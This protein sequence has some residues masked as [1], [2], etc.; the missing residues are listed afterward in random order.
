[1]SGDV[2]TSATNSSTIAAG[3]DATGLFFP[4]E[5]AFQ[6]TDLADDLPAGSVLHIGN[7]T[8]QGYDTYNK[9]GRGGWN[10]NPVIGPT[11]GFWIEA[12]NGLSWDETRPFDF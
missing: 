9:A 8:T 11:T 6:S 3:I 2:N 12:A 1:M 10:G 5:T 4:V 7:D